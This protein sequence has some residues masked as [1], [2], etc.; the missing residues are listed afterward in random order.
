MNHVN[1]TRSIIHFMYLLFQLLSP[2]IGTR[3]KNVHRQ[4]LTCD[5]ISSCLLLTIGKK[6]RQGSLI[7]D[8]GPFINYLSVIG[9]SIYIIIYFI[10]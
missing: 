5:T 1:D 10:T 6:V 8:Y 4:E 7:K 3:L 2:N 9:L